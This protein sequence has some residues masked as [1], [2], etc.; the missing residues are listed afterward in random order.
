MAVLISLLLQVWFLSAS[1]GNG[2]VLEVSS[3]L[4]FVCCVMQ[5]H[6]AR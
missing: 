5:Y 2:K 1:K 4:V 6:Q 3:K